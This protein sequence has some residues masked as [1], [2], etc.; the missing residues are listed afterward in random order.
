MNIQSFIFNWRDKFDSTLA[1]ESALH[2]CIDSVDVI[3]SD[4]NNYR[5]YW[6]NI[7]EDSYFT[8]QFLKAIELHDRKSIFFHV[9]GDTSYTKW[10]QLTKDARHYMQKYNAGIYYPKVKNVEWFD[11]SITQVD[12]VE[13]IDENLKMIANGDETVW[14]IDLRVINYFKDHNFEQFFAC[15]SLGWGFDAV[16]CAISY[17][18]GLP[19]I[20]DS[21]HTIEHPLQTNYNKQQAQQEYDETKR[22][23]PQEIKQYIHH[24]LDT[25]ERFRFL[26]YL[27]I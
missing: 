19:V 23:L 22:R 20:R 2:G 21:N 25:G 7:G 11:D 5:A 13:F 17:I 6:H 27:N 3:N 16:M 24:T 15:N 8:D 18:L 4:D 26:N 12:G 10:T 9:Q 1:I 14:F